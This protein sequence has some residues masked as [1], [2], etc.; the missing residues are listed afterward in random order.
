LQTFVD[1]IGGKNAA[2]AVLTR[3]DRSRAEKMDEKQFV[4]ARRGAHANIPAGR[5]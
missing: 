1:T 4:T 5:N 3:E 2:Q